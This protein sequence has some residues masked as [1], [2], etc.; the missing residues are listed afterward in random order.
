MTNSILLVLIGAFIGWNIPQPVWAKWL[1]AKGVA[2]FGKIRAKFTSKKNFK[3]EMKKTK[4]TK[5]TK[6]TKPAKEVA[7]ESA[8]DDIRGQ[9]HSPEKQQAF[10]DDWESQFG[11]K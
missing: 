8:K 6:V 2:F 1:Q 11:G 7:K 3:S 4:A 9:K 5:K 10:R